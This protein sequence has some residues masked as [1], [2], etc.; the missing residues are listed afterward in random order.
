M[1]MHRF[2]DSG[3]FEGRMQVADLDYVASSV[4]AQTTIT[5]NYVG[6]PL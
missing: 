3:P 5:E 4:A 6:L 1:L 2:P